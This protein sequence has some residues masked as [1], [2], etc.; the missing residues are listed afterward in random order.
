MAYDTKRM[1]DIKFSEKDLLTEYYNYWQNGDFDSLANMLNQNPE[2]KYKILNS[3][4]WNRLINHINDSEDDSEPSTDCIT[5]KWLLDFNAVKL[6]GINF[7]YVGDWAVGATY[8]VGNLVKVDNYHAYYCIGAHVSREDTNPLTTRYSYWMPAQISNSNGIKVTSTLPDAPAVGDLFLYDYTNAV[9]LETA[10]WAQ[11]KD[12]VSRGEADLYWNVG[13]TKTI[14][15][16]GE[17]YSL[18]IS[19]MRKGRY[20]YADSSYG[21]TN[22]AFELTSVLPNDFYMKSTNDN[23]GGYANSD[24]KTYLEENILN[25]LPSDL[26]AVL[27]SIKVPY[28][29]PNDYNLNSYVSEVTCKLFLLSRAEI[30]D[31]YGGNDATAEVLYR[32]EG[33]VYDYYSKATSSRIKQKISTG[34][35]YAWA[36]RTPDI[37]TQE[38]FYAVDSPYEGVIAVAE[39]SQY[40]GISFVIA[41]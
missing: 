13:D 4:N 39:A 3:Y 1:Q 33:N 32:K 14:Q 17:T 24:M 12:I 5:G 18:R 35:N 26:Q 15:I 7:K 11:I 8:R 19:D 2:L 20:K 38:Y 16:D 23:S 36:L 10:S 9:P 30:G 25:K 37:L 28:L 27:Q 31:D 40:V 41:L 6:A 21:K 29:E 22:I 34:E